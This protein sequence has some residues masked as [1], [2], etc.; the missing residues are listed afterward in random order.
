MLLEANLPYDFW[1]K[2]VA[3]TRCT[4]NRSP[5]TTINLKTPEE[6]YGVEGNQIFLI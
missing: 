1:S 2:A 3:T 6:L 4:I 5:Y